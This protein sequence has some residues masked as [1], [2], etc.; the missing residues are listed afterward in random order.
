MGF[1]LPRK[2]TKYHLGGIVMKSQSWLFSGFYFW[3]G[4]F[5]GL[6]DRGEVC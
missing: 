1:L 4:S 2:I 3:F 6:P 5:F